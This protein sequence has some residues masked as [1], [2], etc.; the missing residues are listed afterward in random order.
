MGNIGTCNKLTVLLSWELSAPFPLE[1]NDVPAELN[2]KVLSE[3][4]RKLV[5]EVVNVVEGDTVVVGITVADDSAMEAGK[6]ELGD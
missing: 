2:A 1:G 6:L 3:T 4:G 5:N